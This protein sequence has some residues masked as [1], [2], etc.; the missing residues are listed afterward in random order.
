MKKQI[1][2]TIG[3]LLVGFHNTVLSAPPMLTQNDFYPLH[4]T[5]H[6]FDFLNEQHKEVAKGFAKGAVQERMRFNVTAF[7]QKA[8]RARDQNKSDVPAGDV[9]GRFN[10]VGLLYGNV[11]TGQTRPALLTTAAAQTYHDGQLLNHPNYSDTNDNLGHFSIPLKYRK[12]GARFEF[13]TRI[14]S[15]IVLTV[16]GGI[17]DIKQTYS[18]FNN[19]GRQNLTYL[20]SNGSDYHPTGASSANVTT[21]V[22]TID[23]YL[24]DNHELIFEQMGLNIQDYHASGAEDVFVSLAWRHSFHVNKADGVKHDYGYIN[25]EEWTEFILT[26]FFKITGIVGIGKKT[27]PSKSIFYDYG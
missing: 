1:L 26:P 13:S 11:P 18:T 17:S 27:Q 5:L 8:S 15:D 9:H 10:M 3:L 7:G 25:S 23:Q 21:D 24:M 19:M 12:I 22:N 14:L 20:Q 4:T 2:L 16:E 6:P